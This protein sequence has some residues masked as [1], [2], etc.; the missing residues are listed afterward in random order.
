MKGDVVAVVCDN[1]EPNLANCIASLRR[2]TVSVRVVMASGPKTDLSLAG[3]L[4]DKVYPPISG[5]GRARVNA[6]LKE[7]VDYIISCDSDCIY[8][9]RYIQYAIE[10]LERG[11]KAVKAGVILPLDPSPLGLLESMISP[12]IPYEFAL[13]FKKPEFLKLGLAE[14][15]EKA[16]DPRWDIGRR[17]VTGLNATPDFRM[18]VYTRFPTY[19]MVYVANNYAPSLLA[20][21]LVPGAVLAIV[22]A[23]LQ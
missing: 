14:E 4:A 5:I 10:D 12:L 18:M 16:M 2:Q 17:I 13:A 20:G 6:I 8:D 9:E 22:G 1:G 3:R 19:G 11:A 7:D 15:A 21:A 23:S